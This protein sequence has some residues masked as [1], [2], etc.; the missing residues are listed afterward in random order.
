[1]LFYV[2]YNVVYAASCYVS[3]ALADRFP[4]NRVL[5]IGYSLAIIP[6]IALMLPGASLL[7][8]AIVFGFSGSIW[9]CGKRWKPQ[10]LQ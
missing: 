2:A 7:K 6:A 9:A 1:M 4:K 8:F 5:A 10:R 3:G